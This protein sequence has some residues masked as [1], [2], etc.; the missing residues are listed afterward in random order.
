MAI[1]LVIP[2]PGMK[3]GFSTK[4][5]LSDGQPWAMVVRR[6]S[7]PL[8]DIFGHL[9]WVYGTK[10]SHSF[11]TGAPL[12]LTLC[13]TSCILDTPHQSPPLVCPVQCVSAKTLSFL[14]T[15]TEL[16]PW[17]LCVAISIAGD[18]LGR[19]W[20][21]VPSPM[22]MRSVVCFGFYSLI[23]ES[24]KPPVIWGSKTALESPYWNA[25]LVA[26]AD[27]HMLVLSWNWA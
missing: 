18:A 26:G 13:L 15:E 22:L 7:L 11:L 21:P 3:E 20:L 16:T 1:H 5:G 27:R 6:A 14:S 9:W 2:F 12:P 8:D 17:Y 23:M 25:P 4:K 10:D 19:T 24:S